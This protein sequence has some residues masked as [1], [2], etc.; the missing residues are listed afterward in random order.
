M[1][2]P[3]LYVLSVMCYWL[4]LGGIGSFILQKRPQYLSFFFLLGLLGNATLFCIS[5]LAFNESVMLKIP[6]GI[7]GFPFCFQWDA[8]SAFFV[9]LLNLVV[10][11]IGL[12]SSHYFC[13]EEDRSKSQLCFNYYLFLLSMLWV[14]L[15]ADAFSF[16]VA[17]EL[18]AL[19]SYFLVIG[20]KSG[21]EIGRAAYLYLLLAHVSALMILVSFVFL[22]HGQSEWTFTAMRHV[23][24]PVIYVQLAFFFAIIGFGAKAGLVPL[25]VWLPE[26]HPAAP[27]PISAIM[28]GVMLKTA[29]YGFIRISFDLLNELNFEWGTLVLAIGLLSALFGVILAAIQ[30]DMKRLLAYS[31]I[32]N[33]GIIFTALGL[34]LI[35]KS[36]NQMTLAILALSTALFHCMSHAIFKSL[37]FLGTGNVL[38]ATGE[39]NL[40]K[41][42]GL[43][44]RMP[45]VSAFVLIGVLAISGIP[46]LNGFISEWLLLQSFLFFPHISRPYIIMLIPVAA[47]T[48]AL[49]VGLAAYVMV[50]FYGIIFLGK[51]REPKLHA[52]HDAHFLE[53]AGLFWLTI[54]CL[55][56]GVFPLL[57]LRPLVHLTASLLGVSEQVLFESSNWLF[58][59]PINSQQASYSPIIFLLSIGILFFVVYVVVRRF[60]HGQTRR[61]AAWDCGFPLQTHRSQD[62]A[63]GFGQPIKQIFS[64][65]LRISRELP[66]AFDKLAPLRFKTGLPQYKTTTE[67]RFWYIFYLPLMKATMRCS[68]WISKLQQGKISYYLLY[69]FLTLLLLLGWV[70]WR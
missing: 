70:Q 20:F 21:E 67:D 6:L 56:F 3:L 54:A 57:L 29:V 7:S 15:A 22:L 8:L 17:W 60:Y 25:H 62:T 24:M 64:A 63:E 42:G 10:L 68:E 38:H 2:N 35:F 37:L 18:M 16:L 65:F 41:L 46:P 50:K 51:P 53:K 14:F 28:S 43:I 45:W 52:A 13:H 26:A 5:L 27:S 58:L 9:L 61:G 44:Q 33:I 1:L 36:Y 39:R 40:G 69:S 34:T 55:V 59:V 19:S 12:F 23:D 30:T 31:S 11:G 48:F 47:A 49:V 32:E 66:K 4:I